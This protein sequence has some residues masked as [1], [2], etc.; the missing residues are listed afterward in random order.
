MYKKA[1]PEVGQQEQFSPGKD[2]HP[3]DPKVWCR[4]LS[5]P[6]YQKKRKK[7]HKKKG[8]KT[9]FV[10]VAGRQCL[11]KAAQAA[12][13]KSQAPQQHRALNPIPGWSRGRATCRQTRTH[14]T[15][16]PSRHSSPGGLRSAPLTLSL[17]SD[18]GGLQQSDQGWVCSLI[19]PWCPKCK[20]GSTLVKTMVLNGVILTPID[21]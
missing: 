16:T 15:R 7:E 6:P 17:T 12:A 2:H 5:W 4:L 9:C 18:F 19:N 1:V 3:A 14:H 21:I 10:S 13:G 20:K 11:N 8:D